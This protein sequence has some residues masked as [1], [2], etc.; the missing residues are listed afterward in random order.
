MKQ[1]F[2][3]QVLTTTKVT[4]N[5]LR[6]YHQSNKSHRY[7]WY[8]EAKDYALYLTA[9]HA[10][11]VEVTAGVI[12]ALS[13]IKLW[14]EN[15]RLADQFLRLGNC[16]HVGHLKSKAKRILEL[17]NP[18][19]ICQVLKGRKIT[20]FY[21]NILGDRQVVTV[22]RHALSIALGYKTSDSDY[23]GMTQAQYDFFVGAYQR[24]AKKVGLS[25]CRIQS[26]TWLRY[27]ELIKEKY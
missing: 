26:S 18:E 22:D 20:S 25:P 23:H 19:D 6:I 14:E 15:K 13:P 7:N 27:R 5:I 17:S 8:K 9:M 11:P 4:N 24:A 10:L 12:A 2:K 3:G 1:L 16:G 21:L